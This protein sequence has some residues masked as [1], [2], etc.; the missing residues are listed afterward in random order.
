MPSTDRRFDVVVGTALVVALASSGVG[1][2]LA[3]A[4]AV[5]A[6][7]FR[8]RPGRRTAVAVPSLLW[9][10]WWRTLGNETRRSSDEALIERHGLRVAIVGSAPASG[11]TCVARRVSLRLGD[12][13]TPPHRGP[14]HDGQGA[15]VRVRDG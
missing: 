8:P 2:A 4:C 15:P 7:T 11:P 6:M 13:V 9:V 1:V 10:L 3:A 5:H 14:A 12:E